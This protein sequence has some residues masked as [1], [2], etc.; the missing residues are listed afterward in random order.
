MCP[1]SAALEEIILLPTLSPGNDS[2]QEQKQASRRGSPGSASLVQALG[3]GCYVC[4][5][6]FLH[7][8]FPLSSW[9]TQLQVIKHRITCVH[10][11]IACIHI[12]TPKEPFK[13][14][15]GKRSQNSPVSVKLQL[16]CTTENL[17]L[18]D[19]LQLK[20]PTA[21]LRQGLITA[22]QGPGSS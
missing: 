18:W 13:P 21:P 1:V 6:C 19:H 16:P 17:G 9:P 7:L 11:H 12:E 22:V 3:W 5:S 20:S 15:R 2:E 8:Q 4:K 10:T 14:F